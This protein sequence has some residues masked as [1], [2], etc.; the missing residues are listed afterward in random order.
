METVRL[1]P[2]MDFFVVMELVVAQILP[3]IHHIS[4]VYE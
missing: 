4:A 2:N 1:C 3:I